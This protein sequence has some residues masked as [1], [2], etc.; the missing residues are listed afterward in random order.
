M[1]KVLVIV[2]AMAA[3]GD[4]G[5]HP[6]TAADAPPDHRLD[7]TDWRYGPA[8]EPARSRPSTTA[9]TTSAR[10]SATPTVRRLAAEPVRPEGRRRR[11]RLGP[12]AG[13]R[14]R[15]H[16]GAR[17][18]H[19]VARR[20]RHGRPGHQGPHQPRRGAAAVL[21][22]VADGDCNGDG[23]FDIDRLRRDR[24]PQRQRPR[25]PR[26]P[27]P[28]PGVQ[29]RR[30]RRPQRLRRRHLRA[31]TSSTATTTRSTPSSYGHGTGE[32]K[33]ST[34]AENGTGDVGSCPGCRFLPVRVG[35]SFIA[36]GGRFAAGVLFALDSGADVDPGGA[37]RDQQPAPGAAGDRRRL[38]AR[39]GGGRVDG[40][41]GQ[42]STRTC[43]LAR[44]HDGGQLGDREDRSTSL[45]DRPVDGYLALNGCTNFGGRTFVV[46]PSSACS[47]EATGQSAGMVGLVESYA[48]ESGVEPHPALV[49][50]RRGTTC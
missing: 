14:R 22:G 11:P 48:R 3:P 5:R 19:Q 38:P 32:A 40:R 4:G 17:L 8:D 10:R 37:R 42:R 23:V 7:C 1:R 15:A 6:R 20:R 36:D 41:R 27:H 34:A 46:V 28:R 21:A 39:R 13:P 31:G 12:V 33:D 29:R 2:A 50:R 35:D 24:R 49:G 45:G 18:G 43:R 25:R 26:G 16:R 47:S 44:A 30:R 9:T